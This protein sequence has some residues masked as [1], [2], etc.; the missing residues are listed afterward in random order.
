M[1]KRVYLEITNKCNLNCSFCTNDKGN[2]SLTISEIDN[3]TTQIKEYCNYVYLHILGEPL[4]HNNFEEILNIL[5]K[6]DFQLQLVTNGTLLNRYPDI[7]KHKCLRKLSI[8]IHSVSKQNNEKYFKIINNIIENNSNKYIE[9]RFYDY[10]NLSK[11]IKEYL[12]CLINKYELSITNKEKSYKLKENVYVLF[13]ELFKW[14]NINDEIIS[15]V[16]TCH[17]AIDMIAINS[18]SEVS[19]CCLDPYAFNKIGNLKDNSLKEIL[20]SNIYKQYINEFKN[21][22]ISSELCK[23]CSYRLRFK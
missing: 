10:I 23:R 6:K 22:K 2:D 14:P 3:Y 18:K 19:I 1:L 4:S 8:S 17:G 21:K 16:G 5:D 13:S 20:E 7:L 11:D 15:N 9:L 12:T